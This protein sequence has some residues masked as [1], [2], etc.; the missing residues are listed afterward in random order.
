MVSMGMCGFI[1]IHFAHQFQ[2][3]KITF[4]QKTPAVGLE[5]ASLLLKRLDIE[6]GT[7]RNDPLWVVLRVGVEVVFL[8]IYLCQLYGTF[9]WL[10]W[11]YA[12]SW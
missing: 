11:T 7:Q 4:E 10:I 1:C 2:E 9:C 8:D 12:Q 3:E 5:I 6:F